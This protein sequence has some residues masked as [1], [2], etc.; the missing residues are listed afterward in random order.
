MLES[1]WL[2]RFMGRI[3]CDRQRALAQWSAL[4]HAPRPAGELTGVYWKGRRATRE[5][6]FIRPPRGA[7]VLKA[8]APELSK[9]C[10]P[11]EPIRYDRRCCAS[12]TRALSGAA[13]T[14]GHS[15]TTIRSGLRPI[16]RASAPIKAALLQYLAPDESLL[17]SRRRLGDCA[18][19]CYS[20]LHSHTS[21][22]RRVTTYCSLPGVASL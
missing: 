8:R 3:I 6:T 4:Q 5:E 22:R 1:K 20:A 13:A 9:R 15:T 14:I 19:V 16:V 12:P 17:I 21:V 2:T 11:R 10:T 18:H 7:N